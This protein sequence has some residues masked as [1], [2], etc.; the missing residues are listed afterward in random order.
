MPIL[1]FLTYIL[2]QFYI[3]LG[4]FNIINLGQLIRIDEQRQNDHP[5]REHFR[6]EKTL[7]NLPASHQSFE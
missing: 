3:E 5:E 4:F 7:A 1:Y 6:L 2:K